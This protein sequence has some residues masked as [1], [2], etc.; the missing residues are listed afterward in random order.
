MTDA[1]QDLIARLTGFTPGP[2]AV[3]ATTPGD[4][5][6]WGGDGSLVSNI[7]TRFQRVNVAFDFDEANGTLIAAA[8][9]LHRELTAALAREAGLRKALHYYADFTDDPHDGPWAVNSDD[10]GTVARRA[11]GDAK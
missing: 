6:V 5:V 1:I 11:L 3:D 2:W 9:D 8:P 7:G 4:V 10:F